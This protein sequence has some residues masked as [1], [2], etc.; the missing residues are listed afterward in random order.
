MN[1]VNIFKRKPTEKDHRVTISIDDI[2]TEMKS[3]GFWKKNPPKFKAGNYLEAPSFEL[4]LQCV[5][6][7]NAR[8][9]AKMGKYP[10]DSQ[11]GQMAFRQYDYHSH[12][13]EAQQLLALLRKFDKLVVGK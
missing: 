9:A 6:I 1:I 12:V 13:E 5:F 10:S 3:I 7:P 8:E 4:W 11:V 2:E